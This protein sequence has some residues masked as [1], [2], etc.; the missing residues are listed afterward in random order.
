MA[1]WRF[2]RCL[3]SG[4]IDRRRVVKEGRKQA[5]S[6]CGHSANRARNETLPLP[7]IAPLTEEQGE[8]LEYLEGV[9]PC[10]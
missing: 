6:R 8:T 10:P 9:L 7:V 4:Q 2:L 5:E 1:V 3:V